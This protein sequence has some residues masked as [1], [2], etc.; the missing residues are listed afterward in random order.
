MHKRRAFWAAAVVLTALLYFFENN[1][2]TLTLLAA[3]VLLPLA[4]LLT[5]LCSVS[6][7]LDVT[8]ADEREQH[9]S[10]VVRLKNNGFLPLPSARLALECRDLR[11]GETSTQSIRVDLLPK[12]RR[13]EKFRLA[14]PHCDTVRL[15]VAGLTVFDLFG[16]ARRERPCNAETEYTVLPALFRPEVALADTA[17]ALPDSEVYSNERPGSDPGETFAIREYV[18]GDATRR[19]HWKLSEK[20]DRLMVR[21]FGLPVVNKIL[22]LFEPA[23][24]VDPQVQHAITEVFASLS[25]AL[26]SSGLA[27]QAA[28]TTADGLHMQAVAAQADFDE[29]L[30]A[31]LRLTPDEGGSVVRAFTQAEPHGGFAH[32][33]V[34]AAQLPADVRELHCGNRVSVLLCGEAAVEGLQP[35]GTQLIRFD[36]VNYARTLCRM[37]V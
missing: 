13:E 37:E 21:D 10:G 28:W 3:V 36:S 25:D 35:D 19:I 7:E 9:V 2:A 5:L 23:G 34:V 17:S 4:G 8:G 31:L 32:V 29:M 30:R 16:I 24:S 18:P 22:L 6:A 20:L 27:H 12:E 26:L 11:T 15:R 33:A 1:A 14:C